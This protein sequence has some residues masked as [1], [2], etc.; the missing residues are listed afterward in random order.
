MTIDKRV[1]ERY[2]AFEVVKIRLTDAAGA[3]TLSLLLRD[4][5]KY[6]LGGVYVGQEE[7][8]MDLGYELEDGQEWRPMRLVWKKRVADFVSVVGFLIEET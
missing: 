3:R 7:L 2:P 8:E 6:G 1:H 4:R 5:S